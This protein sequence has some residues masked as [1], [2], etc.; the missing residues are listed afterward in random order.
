MYCIE[1]LIIKPVQVFRVGS[2]KES[3][4]IGSLCRG[5][6]AGIPGVGAEARVV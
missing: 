4:I 5:Q 2:A 3:I 1:S 6:P